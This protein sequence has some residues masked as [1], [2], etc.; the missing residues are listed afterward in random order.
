M[1]PEETTGHL[2]RSPKMCHASRRAFSAHKRYLKSAPC[3][4]FDKSRVDVLYWC[5]Q[6]MVKHFGVKLRVGDKELP[7]SWGD[8]TSLDDLAKC[9]KKFLE[10]LQM[11]RAIGKYTVRGPCDAESML[12]YFRVPLSAHEM[13]RNRGDHTISRDPLEVGWSTRKVRGHQPQPRSEYP[14]FASDPTVSKWLHFN[15]S[16]RRHATELHE[17]QRSARSDAVAQTTKSH[18]CKGGYGNDTECAAV[19]SDP[20]D[21][22]EDGDDVEEGEEEECDDC[23]CEESSS[24]DDIA[25]D[26]TTHDQGTNENAPAWI[27]DTTHSSPTALRRSPKLGDVFERA[28][29]T[30][31]PKSIASSCRTEDTR[32]ACADSPTAAP[33]ASVHA[34]VSRKRRA[35]RHDPRPM[36]CNMHPAC[37]CVKSTA[38]HP[39]ESSRNTCTIRV[40]DCITKDGR[41]WSHT[42]CKH[43]SSFGR[44]YCERRARGLLC[45]CKKA[46]GEQACGVRAM[47]K[48]HIDDC[49]NPTKFSCVR[50]HPKLLT[51]MRTDQWCHKACVNHVRETDVRQHGRDC[52]CTS[53]VRL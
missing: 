10:Y 24:D 31:T 5:Q 25:E 20:D 15:G 40:G 1:P 34:E 11:A 9:I 19:G 36:Y 35:S 48:I 51:Q 44:R 6:L 32:G 39:C 42:V 45:D 22:D 30:A 12:K 27:D 52:L 28:P 46:Q 16:C 26:L 43:V 33:S 18:A 41:G 2:L 50:M 7:L 38:L 49:L 14:D 4:L 37:S 47:C 29:A 13:K 3:Q 53:C 17:G 8:I 23:D 21:R